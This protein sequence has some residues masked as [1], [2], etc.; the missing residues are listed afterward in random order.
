VRQSI[1][2]RPPRRAIRV[3]A[4]R[5]EVTVDLLNGRVT[6]TATG[7]AA[8][9]G[10]ADYQRNQMFIEEARHFLACVSGEAQPLIPLDEGIDVLRVAL[11]VKEAMRTGTAAAI[12]S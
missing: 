8:D 11:A 4:V 7:I 6:S 1:A 2:V 5:G 10:F 9:P 12:A 3:T